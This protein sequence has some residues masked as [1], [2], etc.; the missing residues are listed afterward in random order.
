MKNVRAALR[1]PAFQHAFNVTYFAREWGR[2]YY[3][4]VRNPDFM[5]ADMQRANLEIVTLAEQRADYKERAEIAEAE[6]LRLRG[7][8]TTGNTE[9]AVEASRK[10]YQERGMWRMGLV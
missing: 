10:L 7:C 2:P 1:I 4:S 5:V 8:I 9:G 6:V 3:G